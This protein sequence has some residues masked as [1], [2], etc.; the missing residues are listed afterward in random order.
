MVG[1]E[2]ILSVVVCCAGLLPAVTTAHALAADEYTFHVTSTADAHDAEPG[3]PICATGTG[4]CTLRA[5]VE[6]AS[7]LPS[8]TTVTVE[9]PAGTYDLTLGSLDARAN[10]VILN[11]A[12][13]ASALIDARGR[14]RILQVMPAASVTIRGL[15]LTGGSVAGYGGAVL[16]A[17]QLLVAHSDFRDDTAASGGALSNAGGSTRIL[18][19]DFTGDNDGGGYGGGAIQ[20]G[21]ISNLP[22]SVS[23]TDSVFAHDWAGGNGGA[24]LNGQ[25]GQP[26][27]AGAARRVS[28]SLAA[29]RLTVTGSTFSADESA[30]A[31]GAIADQGGLTILS[32]DLFS[33]DTAPGAVGG[34]I[35]SYGTLTLSRSTLSRNSSCYGGAIELAYGGTPASATIGQSTF[36]SNQAGCYGG[37]IDVSGTLVTLTQSTLAGN[38]SADGGAAVEIEGSSSGSLANSTF[39]GNTGSSAIETFE[40]SPADLSFDTFSGNTAALELSC[41]DSTVLGTILASSAGANCTG[42]APVS[43]GYNLESGDSCGLTKPTDITGTEPDLGPLRSNGGPTQTMALLAGSPA[44]GRG[45]TRATGCPR[46]D[47]RGVRRPQGSRCDIGA[48][49]KTVR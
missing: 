40:C 39:Y 46:V 28:R 43:E 37:A 9:I 18:D 20:N 38:W 15:T 8:G 48:F 4:T 10:T 26:P 35:Y 30:N 42:D 19:S 31:G 33:H 47:E 24:I 12:G 32:G 1:R 2:V 6:A 27:A 5:A 34:A 29:L 45:G 25:N 36:T 22:G 44:L 16:N 21:G 23:V 3:E 17:G 41:R 11:G 14:S 7:A 13:A 49:E